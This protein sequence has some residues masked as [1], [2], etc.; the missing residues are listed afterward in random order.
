V[1]RRWGRPD[2]QDVSR[3]RDSVARRIAAFA[4]HGDSGAV[5]GEEAAREMNVLYRAVR[6]PVPDLIGMISQLA[7]L[8]WYRAVASPP[9]ADQVD[10]EGAVAIFG[11]LHEQEADVE[12]PAALRPLLGSGI[13]L[14][15]GTFGLG[16][17][18]V[19]LYRTVDTAENPVIALRQAADLLE[20]VLAVSSD[21]DPNL[22]IALNNL[23]G[24]HDL[25]YDLSQDIADLDAAIA[26]LKRA[27]AVVEP[28]SAKV[29]LLS[30]AGSR[31]YARFQRG[32]GTSDLTAAIETFE[33]A[34]GITPPGDPAMSN[35]TSNL[36]AAYGAR[37]AATGSD[38]DLDT[39]V[40]LSRLV[41]DPPEGAPSRHPRHLANYAVTLLT[42]Y[43]RVGALGDLDTAIRLLRTAVRTAPPDDPGRGMY[44][45]N[46]GTALNLR[47]E[48]A[49]DTADLDD[50][51]EAGTAAVAATP[52]G[53]L[54]KPGR[55]SNL[56][57]ALANRFD[58]TRSADDL[59]AA[60]EHS[61]LAL[62]SAPAGHPKR[63]LYVSNFASLLLDQWELSQADD[64]LEM[65][66]RAG[67]AALAET[68]RDH[69][70]RA[71]VATQLAGVL[72]SRAMSSRLKTDLL[73]AWT[74]CREAALCTTAAISDR[75]RAARLWADLSVLVDR[76]SAV[77]GSAQDSVF[78]GYELAVS[79]LPLLAW[80]GT[81]RASRE[82]QLTGQVGVATNAAAAALAVNQPDRAV[83]WL[84]HGRAVL[85]SR[86]LETNVDL[87]TLRSAEPHL[88]A[89]LDRVRQ[90]LNRLG[91]PAFAPDGTADLVARWE[92][93]GS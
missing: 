30:I 87:E 26:A 91:E 1:K 31:Q 88:A 39:A 79:L 67:Q 62:R 50:S 14:R 25:R 74:A 92:E 44:L 76:E 45:T 86:T 47:W 61:R 2:D 6:S 29:N 28:D 37:F 42:R 17:R 77:P 36:A 3:A 70:A 65:A 78:E 53:D 54:D 23:A 20:L 32:G 69:P 80:P 68:S 33:Q 59:H 49:G 75:A 38:A 82:R 15:G 84:E 89:E 64:D 12:V 56:A 93:G 43:D 4:E 19:H 13:D 55:H 81:D 35:L 66:V 52:D 27:A 24:V 46:L 48:I 72:V 18:A 83:M 21:D 51:V 63:G 41:V 22:P 90:E 10:L 60:I 71:K 5:L 40:E 11:L 8:H 58:R 16:Q 57:R 34:R 85:W 73:D 7:W 9:G